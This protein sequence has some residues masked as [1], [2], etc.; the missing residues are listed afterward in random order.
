[1]VSDIKKLKQVNG[2]FMSI[3]TS[4]YQDFEVKVIR[5][6]WKYEKKNLFVMVKYI[7]SVK[8]TLP[9]HLESF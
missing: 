8:T 4:K 5:R 2:L 6:F 3:N 1:M 7:M 9:D